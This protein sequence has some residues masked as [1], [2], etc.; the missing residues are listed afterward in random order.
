MRFFKIACASVCITVLGF[1]TFGHVA[2]SAEPFPR[3]FSPAPKDRG[4]LQ[5]YVTASKAAL[6]ELTGFVDETS[7][8]AQ[9][10]DSQWEGVV[11]RI[12]AQQKKLLADGHIPDKLREWYAKEQLAWANI[13]SIGAEMLATHHQMAST[14]D[15]IAMDLDD[16][17][18][19]RND[20]SKRLERL[21]SDS[22][23]LIGYVGKLAKVEDDFNAAKVLLS[24]VNKRLSRI[25]DTSARVSSI[26]AQRQKDGLSFIKKRDLVG[27]YRDRL[28]A[29][30]SREIDP[31]GKGVYF[32][33]EADWEEVMFATWRRYQDVVGDWRKANKWLTKDEALKILNSKAQSYILLMT[34]AALGVPLPKIKPN[35]LA[36]LPAAADKLSDKVQAVMVR[37]RGQKWEVLEAKLEDTRDK[38]AEVSRNFDV[39]VEKMRQDTNQKIVDA[40]DEAQERLK[41]IDTREMALYKKLGQTVAGTSASGRIEDDLEKLE[42]E[43]A[44]VTRELNKTRAYYEGPHVNRELDRLMNARNEALMALEQELAQVGKEQDTLE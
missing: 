30:K 37:I 5:N 38:M 41:D 22:K 18:I 25:K 12:V 39:E 9:F 32:D 3:G 44:L 28:N 13:R 14:V 24:Q 2:Q 27:S 35:M 36:N 1:G 19:F 34:G 43:R 31:D 15:E 21:E 29:L 33:A 10:V 42:A 6:S 17:E 26:L 16:T 4:A 8:G 7:Q 23:Q 20:W 40:E 11:N